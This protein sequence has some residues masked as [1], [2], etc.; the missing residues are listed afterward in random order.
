MKKFYRIVLYLS[1]FVPILLMAQGN[2]LDKLMDR[3]AG[4]KGV[5]FLDLKTNMVP[6]KDSAASGENHVIRVKML[7]VNPKLNSAVEPAA[8]YDE[9]FKQID[10]K[11]YKGLVEVKSSGDN[12]EM[13]VK[14]EGGKISELIIAVKEHDETTLIAAS[15]DFDLKELARLSQLKNCK[16]L[17]VLNSL[18]EE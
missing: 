3:Y 14:E 4:M 15:G 17:Q 13:M 5:M 9:F 16:G 18:C 10:R 8:M 11:G 7:S 1:C 6:V 12:V 2:P